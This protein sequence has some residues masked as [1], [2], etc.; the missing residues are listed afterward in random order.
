MQHE[1]TSHDQEALKQEV[2]R[3]SKS[4]PVAI[5]MKGTPQFPVC[6]FSAKACQVLAA[7]GVSKDD[8]AAFD[9][10]SDE[11]MWGA[12]EAVTEWPTVPQIFVHGQFIGGC[13]IVTEMFESGELQKLLA[14]K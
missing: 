14:S 1:Q 11:Q 9:V 5:Y 7:A 3:F 13:D 4:K 2:V 12:L 8:L 10:L 6:G